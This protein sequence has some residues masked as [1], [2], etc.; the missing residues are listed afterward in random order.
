MALV[1]DVSPRLICISL[2]LAPK[3]DP[4]KVKVMLP[5]NGELAGLIDVST[6]AS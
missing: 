5:V 1:Q 2:L 3:L 4:N 6:G